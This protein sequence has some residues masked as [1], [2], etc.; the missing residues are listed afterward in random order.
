[1]KWRVALR[2]EVETDVAEAAGWY[3][4]RQA[5]LGRRFAEEVILGCVAR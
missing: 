3:E 4:N 5:G 1:M 2:P